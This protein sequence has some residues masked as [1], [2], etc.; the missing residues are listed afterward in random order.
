MTPM[1]KSDIWSKQ[2]YDKNIFNWTI[3]ENSTPQNF[4]QNTKQI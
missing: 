1:E 2:N 4:E 3:S